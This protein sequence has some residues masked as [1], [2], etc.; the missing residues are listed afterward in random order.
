MGVGN[1]GDTG[2]AVN[3]ALVQ[4]R[5]FAGADTGVNVTVS[6][7]PRTGDTG[8]GFNIYT[9]VKNEDFDTGFPAH[10]VRYF[11]GDRLRVRASNDTGVVTPNHTGGTMYA[12]F[13]AD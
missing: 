13:D 3:G 5:L 7:Q 6:F 2:P 10:Q 11:A 1:K 8:Q 9:K 12:W 4:L